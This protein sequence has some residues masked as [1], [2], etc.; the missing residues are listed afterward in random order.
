MFVSTKQ[1]LELLKTNKTSLKMC[2]NLMTRF[3]KALLIII[4][5]VCFGL[6]ATI[7]GLGAWVLIDKDSLFNIVKV[8]SLELQPCSMRTDDAA[9]FGDEINTYFKIAS[10]VSMGAG[11]LMM[12][13]R[14][15]F[16]FGCTLESKRVL[17]LYACLAVIIVIIQIR[18]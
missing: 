5:V 17:Q 9:N 3:T 8:A 11:S 1:S 13:I 2:G 7:F 6:A 18:R 10:Y 14:F 4:N 16:C 15:F 12:M